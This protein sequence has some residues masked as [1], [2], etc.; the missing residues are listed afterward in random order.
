[1]ITNDEIIESAEFVCRRVQEKHDTEVPLRTV[2]RLMSKQLGMS[3]R[4]IRL[5]SPATNS[6]RNLILRQKYALRL[7]E[8]LKQ[9]KRVI[10][11]DESFLNE[12]EQRKMKWQV[13]CSPTTTRS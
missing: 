7:I 4:K 6:L 12:T 1:M 11:I 5:I 2:Q 8:V 10:N 13:R 3:Y 9:G